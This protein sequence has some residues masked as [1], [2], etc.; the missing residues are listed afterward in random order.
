MENAF[1]T[2][3][4]KDFNSFCP[5]YSYTTLNRRLCWK[6][7]DKFCTINA[8]KWSICNGI[9]ALGLTLTQSWTKLQIQAMNSHLQQSQSTT[10]TQEEFHHE[11]IQ[12]EAQKLTTLFYTLKTA[13]VLV[14]VR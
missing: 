10:T 3:F 11:E 14:S 4:L 12:Q 2:L 9:V 13:L 1:L 8:L 6:K 5:L 7:K